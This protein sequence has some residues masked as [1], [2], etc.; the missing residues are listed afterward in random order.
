MED[1]IVGPLTV[2]QFTIVSIFGFAGLFILNMTFIGQNL[3]Y[4]LAGGVALV[5]LILAMGK[6]NDQPLF[7]FMKYIVSFIFSPKTRVWRKTGGGDNQLVTPTQ[8]DQ[9]KDSQKV[10][11]IIS[12]DD[13]ARIATVVDSRGVR[14]VLPKAPNRKAE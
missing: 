3:R 11:K 10:R 12:K 9:S 2:I 14:G 7:R 13:I 1:K 4:G 5:G 6:F 8:V